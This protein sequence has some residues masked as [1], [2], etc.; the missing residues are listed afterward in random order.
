[1]RDTH[2]YH[3]HERTGV[4]KN[5]MNIRHKISNDKQFNST[6][7]TKQDDTKNNNS[8]L[9]QL[10]KTDETKKASKNREEDEKREKMGWR[11]L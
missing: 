4:Y 10:Y 7:Q 11:R 5:R 6:H 1:M 9:T 3:E 8:T 2:I